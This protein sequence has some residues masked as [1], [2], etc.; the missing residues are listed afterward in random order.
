[1]R[2][3]VLVL[4]FGL[5]TQAVMAKPPLRDVDEIDNALLAVGL[6]NEIRSN[7]PSISARMLKAVLFVHGLQTRAEELGYS[8]DEI[9][10]YRKSDAEKARLRAEGDAWLVANGV[11]KAEPETYCAAGRA[12]IEKQSQIGALLEVN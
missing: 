4:V 8:Q 6:A 3:W 11:D 7:C 12:E 10:A 9:D 5:A 1:M 2:A